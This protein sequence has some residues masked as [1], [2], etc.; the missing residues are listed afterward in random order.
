MF[1][2]CHQLGVQGSMPSIVP[3]ALGIPHQRSGGNGTSIGALPQSTDHNNSRSPSLGQPP[4]AHSVPTWEQRSTPPKPVQPERHPAYVPDFSEWAWPVPPR[5][6][7][8][9]PDPASLGRS[10]DGAGASSPPGPKA[11]ARRTSASTQMAPTPEPKPLR[12]Q[13]SAQEDA[14][15]GARRA[16]QM[17]PDAKNSVQFPAQEDAAPAQGGSSAG[18]SHEDGGTNSTAPGSGSWPSSRSPTVEATTSVSSTSGEARDPQTPFSAR[19]T[20][21]SEGQS[22][23]CSKSSQSSPRRASYGMDPLLPRCFSMYER[24]KVRAG[25]FPCSLIY[26]SRSLYAYHAVDAGTSFRRDLP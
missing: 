24:Q 3:P 2:M 25:R 16:S 14:M 18:T 26:I 21:A 6:K 12:V 20:N 23:P 4:N 15:A 8:A 7:P 5:G 13:R 22:R 9:D 10:P 17:L 19:L 1:C 11:L